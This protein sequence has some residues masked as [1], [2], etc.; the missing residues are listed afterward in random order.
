M[1][2]QSLRPILWTDQLD[3]TIHFYVN[4]LG[5]TLG[6]RS[7]D[8]GWASLYKDEVGIMLA[9]PNAHTPIEKPQFTGSFYFNTDEVDSLW[10]ELKIKARVCYEI[11]NFEWGMREFAIYD[12]NGYLLQFG[13]EIISES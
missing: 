11:E 6:E 1:K 9:K 8:W 12:N 7:D 3:E 13:Q 2:F 4:V 10:S 5:F